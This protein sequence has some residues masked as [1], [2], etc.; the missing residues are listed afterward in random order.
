MTTKGSRQS[1]RITRARSVGS[2][3]LGRNPT[4]ARRSERADSITCTSPSSTLI[5]TSGLA[6]LNCI[7][8][9]GRNSEL[10]LAKLAI[11]I[12]PAI[13]VLVDRR[14]D[15]VSSTAAMIDRALGSKRF[16]S[17]V[18]VRGRSRRSIKVH[19]LGR[20]RESSRIYNLQPGAEP[21]QFKIHDV[22]LSTNRVAELSGDYVPSSA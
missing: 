8:T 15:T 14:S 13:V 11:A 4:E 7:R 3:R 10:A 2:G 22:V 16:P 17:S 19:P 1:G 20:L 12:L 9:S 6:D 18:S 21:R 5:S